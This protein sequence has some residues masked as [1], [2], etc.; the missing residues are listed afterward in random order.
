MLSQEIWHD[1]LALHDHSNSAI[2]QQKKKQKNNKQRQ[3]LMQLEMIVYV[4]R[5]GYSG[6][7]K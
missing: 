7:Y 3:F 6:P 5:Y 4:N 2:Y 1:L